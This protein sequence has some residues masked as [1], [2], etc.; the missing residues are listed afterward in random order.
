MTH[1][2]A[3]EL[4]A[5]MGSALERAAAQIGDL[6]RPVLDRVYRRHPEAADAFV[7]LSSGTITELEGRMVETTLFCLTKWIE[8]QAMVEIIIH[9]SLPHHAMT[10]GIDPVLFQSLAEETADIIIATI[11]ADRG[12][13]REAWVQVRL[14]LI[15]AMAKA[16]ASPMLARVAR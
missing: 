11:P 13:E 5:L 9:D 6:T 1:R 16:R 7:R 15:G 3:A 10:L 8:E 12:D 14:G 2:P 4:I